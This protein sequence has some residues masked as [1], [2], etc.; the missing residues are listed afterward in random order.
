MSDEVSNELLDG[1]C[2]VVSRRC[3]NSRTHLG[4]ARRLLP[5]QLCRFVNQHLGR[6]GNVLSIGTCWGQHLPVI[7]QAS[8]HPSA[9]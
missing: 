6:H 1:T 2:T 5:R 4:D 9:I 3:S 8:L 7:I